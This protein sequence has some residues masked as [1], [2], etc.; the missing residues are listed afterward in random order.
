MVS[1]MPVL[2][3]AVIGRATNN[4]SCA[5]YTGQYMYEHRQAHTSYEATQYKNTAYTAYT[6]YMHT[7]VHSIHT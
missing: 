3:D 2:A 4:T 5:S 1:V 7:Y 6:A